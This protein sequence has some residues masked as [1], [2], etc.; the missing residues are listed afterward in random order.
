VKEKD[1]TNRLQSALRLRLKRSWWY[2]I[3]DP[4]KCPRCNTIALVSKRPFDLIGSW[5]GALIAIEIKVNSIKDLQPHQD[6]ALRLVEQAEGIA[7]VYVGGVVYYPMNNGE[8]KASKD[9]V[10]TVIENSV[11]C[12]NP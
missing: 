1:L 6:A 2:K 8:W 7:L 4:A 10:F 12:Y 9:D 5:R 11:N 3:P